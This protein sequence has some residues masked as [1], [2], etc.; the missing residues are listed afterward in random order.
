MG[1]GTRH[2]PALRRAKNPRITEGDDRL[3]WMDTQEAIE[4][5]IEIHGGNSSS[6]WRMYRGFWC[7]SG[8]TELIYT[9][10][11]IVNAGA[12]RPAEWI[13]P[14]MVTRVCFLD[15][16]FTSGGDRTVAYFG[17]VGI[18]KGG[19]KTL[20]YN[21]YEIFKDDVTDRSQ[22]RSQQVI[23]WWR[24]LCDAKGVTHVTPGSTARGA[25]GPFG[26]LGRHPLEQGSLPSQLCRCR[27][28]GQSGLGLRR[29]PAMRALLQ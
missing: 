6:F 10:I 7:P 9:E 4:R 14:A 17:T 21:N 5:E 11:E 8:V 15:P 3:V 27:L 23:R 22:T 25:G 1:D 2:L 29:H 28:G 24:G 20:E 13:D 18:A 26:D 12:D 16:A 19:L